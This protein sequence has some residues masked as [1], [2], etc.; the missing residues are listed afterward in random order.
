MKLRL[1]L[2]I[3]LLLGFA[4]RLYHL[5]HLS[6]WL[7]ES[8]SIFAAHLALP[9][10][11]QFVASRSHPPLY[12]LQLHGWIVLGDSEFVVRF[13]S[14][15]WGMVGIAALYALG[16]RFLGVRTGTLAALLLAVSPI[17]V[18]HSQDARMYTLLLSLAILSS[19][20]LLRALT[21]SRPALWLAY[22]LLAAGTLYTHN[23]AALTLAAQALL[24]VIYIVATR[25]WQRLRGIALALTILAVLYLPWLPLAASQAS[26]LQ[27]QFWI[28][29]PAPRSILDTFAYL[30][31]AFLFQNSPW[32]S[33]LDTWPGSLLY[34]TYVG[35]FLLGAWQVVCRR[36]HAL[37][38]FLLIVVPIAGEYAVS[39]VRPIYLNRT[40]LVAA[41]PLLILYAAG[42]FQRP[43]WTRRAAHALLVLALALNVCSLANMFRSATKEGWR[44]AARLVSD[45]A[46]PG[47]AIFFDQGV[48]QV[49]F[50]Y[51]Y[52]RS[53]LQ[54]HEYGYPRDYTYWEEQASLEG[55]QWWVIDYLATDPS[56]DATGPCRLPMAHNAV[57]RLHS[58]TSS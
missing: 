11:L 43:G 10:L 41:A 31:S 42:T 36:Y 53:G 23:T 51:Y 8:H 20:F 57:P 50:D 56:T 26:R 6:V 46:Q 19:Y 39:L 34:L 18:W 25:Q 35:M 55:D 29:P 52:H 3:I 12:F 13:L 27:Q 32:H 37:F 17:H 9:E 33:N 54:L 4:L 2:L 30:S 21:A 1:Y 40:L 16:R 24:A 22:G 28:T 38:L 58:D 45:L 7:D 5:A 14:V 48:V 15:V 49:P 47:E 44:E